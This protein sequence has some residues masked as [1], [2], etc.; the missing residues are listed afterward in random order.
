MARSVLG[1]RRM[2]LGSFRWHTRWHTSAVL[3]ASFAVGALASATPAHAAC[4]A[5]ER[6][7]IL[8][9]HPAQGAT[10]VPT[11]VD[12][13]V[14]LTDGD[15]PP[16]VSL[17]D[18]ELPGLQLP[19]NYDLGELAP[20]TE[21][22]LKV[23]GDPDSA[24]ELRFTTGS[25]AAE[26]DPDAAPGM[27][28][29]SSTFDYAAPASLCQAIVNN[30]GCFD[31]PPNTYYEFAPS[32]NAVGWLVHSNDLLRDVLWPSECGP[33]QLL[34]QGGAPCVVLS[35]IDASGATHASEEVCGTYSG[36]GQ[37]LVLP[38]ERTAAGTPGV[39]LPPASAGG[40]ESD[41]EGAAVS[42]PAPQMTASGGCALGGSRDARGSHWA[43][44]LL[45]TLGGWRAVRRR[46]GARTG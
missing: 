13:W 15:E 21:Y 37:D 5:S 22:L 40:D 1:S 38:P 29:T 18:A 31:T 23:H 36:E 44:A 9:S 16:R 30:Q 43:L 6:T 2:G 33:L 41:G 19:F 7:G 45:G 24:F 25:G 3:S 11:N 8:W 20:N 34:T 14:M 28:T 12:L 10:D 26:V 35:G 32:G 42:A 27:V 46:R 39:V 4:L 17:G